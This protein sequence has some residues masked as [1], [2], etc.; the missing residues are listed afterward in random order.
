MVD[1]CLQEPSYQV[2]AQASFILKWGSQVKHFLVPV[3]IQEGRVS[4]FLPAVIHNG[5]GQDVSCE[6]NKSILA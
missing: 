2:R 4:F 6:L 5:P 1:L 3:S